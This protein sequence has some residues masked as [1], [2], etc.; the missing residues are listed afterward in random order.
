MAGLIDF[1]EALLDWSL[2]L[3]TLLP[4]LAFA[5]YGLYTG[6]VHLRNSRVI[7][8]LSTSRIHSA[9]QGYVELQGT[10]SWLQPP[11]LHSPLSRQACV[12]WAYEIASKSPHAKKAEWKII[13]TKTSEDAFCLDDGTG[14]CTVS[15]NREDLSSIQLVTPSP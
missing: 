15:G 9:A 4:L 1:F 11:G 8:G 13:T 12:W 10:A 2:Y 5:L 7:A 3:G 14:S 6:G